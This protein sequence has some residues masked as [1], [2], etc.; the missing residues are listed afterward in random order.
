MTSGFEWNA[1]RRMTRRDLVVRGMS[2]AA[3]GGLLAA[4]GGE[5]DSAP[6]EGGEGG[7]GDA[8]GV[9]EAR[10]SVAKWEKAP[11]EFEAPGPEFDATAAR[12]R[13]VWAVLILSIP[14]AQI[15][16]AGYEEALTAAGIELVK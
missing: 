5:E 1:G 9:D 8:K 14:F 4:C 10:S 11:S 3:A 12:G 13:T 7:G 16:A 6:T 15:N 2:L